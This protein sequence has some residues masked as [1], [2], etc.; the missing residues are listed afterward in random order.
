[1]ECIMLYE[2]LQINQRQWVFCEY[3]AFCLFKQNATHATNCNINKCRNKIGI[4]FQLLIFCIN[5]D[6]PL[7]IINIEYE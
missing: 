6:K 5:I 2:F 4:K 3:C 1:M 7:H